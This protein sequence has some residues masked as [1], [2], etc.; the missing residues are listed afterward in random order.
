MNQV[1][2][3]EIKLNSFILAL[4]IVSPAIT[5]SL[6][7]GLGINSGGNLFVLLAITVVFLLKTIL[8]KKISFRLNLSIAMLLVYICLYYGFSLV[9]FH[10]YM[11]LSFMQFLFYGLIPILCV[12][13]KTNTKTVLTYCLYISPVT[14]LGGNRWF[15]YLYAYMNQAEMGYIY[16]IVTILICFIFHFRYYRKESSNVYIKACYVYN[17]YLLIRVLLVANRGAFLT[18]IVAIFISIIYDFNS[19]GT[20]KRMA[21]KQIILFGSLFIFS[22]I[23]VSNLN[24]VIEYVSDFMKN[25]FGYI[26]SFFLKMRRYSEDLS[27]GRNEILDIVLPAIKD[28]FLFGLK[29]GKLNASLYL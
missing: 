8:C 29:E 28:N 15:V 6:L 1:D 12:T 11:S 7:L 20:M 16:P 25:V 21:Y 22:F 3:I 5:V 18:I 14:F 2:S 4:V 23:V 10:T 19:Y 13:L 26:P 17:I 9:F 27:N 24:I